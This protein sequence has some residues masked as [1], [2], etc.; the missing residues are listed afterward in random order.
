M[1]KNIYIFSLKVIIFLRL[2]FT[3][4]SILFFLIFNLLVPEIDACEL[5]VS[6]ENSN[7]SSMR[8]SFVNAKPEHK[9]SRDTKESNSESVVCHV[10]HICRSEVATDIGFKIFAIV[11]KKHAI[12]FN[13]LEERYLDRPYR[14]PDVVM[15]IFISQLKFNNNNNNNFIKGKIYEKTINDIDSWTSSFSLSNYARFQERGCA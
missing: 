10:A 13:E 6:I 5:K 12:D 8:G 4:F 2:Y 1:L 3:H 7:T 14:P 11:A 15:S 9:S